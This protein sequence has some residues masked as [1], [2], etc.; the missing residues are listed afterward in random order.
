MATFAMINGNT[1]DN[2]I[3]ADNKEATEEALRCTLIEFTAENPAG[4]GWTWDGSKFI[5]PIIEE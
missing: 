2:I 3:V 4:I 1:V 5:E